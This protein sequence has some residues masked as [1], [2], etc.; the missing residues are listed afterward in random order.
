VSTLFAPTT[1]Q[2]EID[3]QETPPL[4]GDINAPSLCHAADPPVGFVELT[5]LP[6]WSLA[7]H[8][9]TDGHDTPANPTDEGLVVSRQPAK[10][11]E[12]SANESS[13]WVGESVPVCNETLARLVVLPLLRSNSASFSTTIGGLPSSDCSAANRPASLTA[14]T[15]PQ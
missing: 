14:N 5:T 7:T 8:N 11:L 9:D 10:P 6:T 2:S 12:S 1:A 13:P 15:G 4:E 3:G